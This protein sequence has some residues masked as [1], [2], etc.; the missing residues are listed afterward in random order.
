[1]RLVP[2]KLPLTAEMCRGAAALA[3]LVQSCSSGHAHILDCCR[4][5]CLRQ[6]ACAG[7]QLQ[8][9]LGGLVLLEVALPRAWERVVRL[10]FGPR[11]S[12]PLSS[13]LWLEVMGRCAGSCVAA[14]THPHARHVIFI[15]TASWTPRLCSITGA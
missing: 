3:R 4:Q 13:S 1:M 11:L 5:S 12:D 15:V 2:A 10:R 14:V 8:A 9:A 7:E 6:A